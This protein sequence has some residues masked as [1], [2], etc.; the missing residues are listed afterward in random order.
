MKPFI[1]CEETEGIVGQ[2]YLFLM[3]KNISFAQD[4]TI[5]IHVWVTWHSNLKPNKIISVK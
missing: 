4:P 1:V 3:E 2:T 5:Y